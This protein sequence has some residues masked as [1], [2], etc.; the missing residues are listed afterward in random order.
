MAID[1]GTTN[2]VVYVRGH[3]IV[4]SEPNLVAVD[5]GTGEVRAVGIEAKRLREGGG[6]SITAVRPLRDGVV[7]DFERTEESLR[8]FMRKAL[9]SRTA[10]PRMVVVGVPSGATS[11]EKPAVEEACLS[12]GA[13]HA[14][15]IEE[16]W[17]SVT[18]PARPR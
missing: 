4:L 8:W 17:T 1:L 14:G 12:A 18:A 2:V 6:G 11:V 10:H 16:W 15:L 7:V 3:G 13:R 9:R 5:S